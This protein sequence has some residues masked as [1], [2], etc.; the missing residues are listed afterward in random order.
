MR[1]RRIAS[2][3]LTIAVLAAAPAIAGCGAS[4]P[5]RRAGPQ[6]KIEALREAQEK[7]QSQIEAE[8]HANAQQAAREQR[9]TRLQAEREGDD[10]TAPAR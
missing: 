2:L 1:L 10:R 3:I 8:A 9:A 6:G 7:A 4:A 5:Q